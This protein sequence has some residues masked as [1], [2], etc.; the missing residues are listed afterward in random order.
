MVPGSIASTYSTAS[1]ASPVGHRPRRGH[2][3]GQHAGPVQP[4]RGADLRGVRRLLQRHGRRRQEPRRQHRHLP[5]LSPTTAA[6]PGARRS[7]STTT[8]PI[9]DGSTESNDNTAPQ[10]EITGRI[11]FQPAIAVDPVTGTLVAV[12]AR[13]PR[14]RRAAPGWRPTSPASID[15]GNTFSVQTY[16]N[17][18]QTATD[19]ITGQTDRPGPGG[20]Q[21]PSGD[22]NRRC[23][24]R[25]RHLDG[26]GRLRRPGLSRSGP[27]TSTRPRWSTTPSRVRRCR[28]TTGRWSSRPG[29]GS[30]TAPWARSPTPR[31]RAAG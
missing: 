18:Q 2:G 5:D 14:R 6:G 19:A 23:H 4:V 30:S 27:A 12:V 22:S 17:P 7:R 24:L 11:Q 10:D 15:G 29:R 25:L 26:P 9:A 21:R 8:R 16:A 3:A 20:G 28:S 1:A 13:R 31:P